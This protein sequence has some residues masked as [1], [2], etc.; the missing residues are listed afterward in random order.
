MN[1]VIFL[2]N[3]T[4]D[5]ELRHSQG[6]MGIY[7]NSLAVSRKF[8]KNGEKQEEVLFVDFT[9]FARTSE[10]CNQYLKKG[11]KILVEGRLNFEQWIGED[12]QKR[13]KHSVTV[14]SMQMLDSKPDIGYA[15]TRDATTQGQNYDGQGGY[16]APVQQTPAQVHG[17]DGQ[18][19]SNG[20]Q[21]KDLPQQR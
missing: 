12:G 8:T 15:P 5:G 17:F 14:E 2:G 1:K 20:Y 18:Q 9:A 11:S 21:Q 3:C 4:K 6:G 7:K 19:Q 13:S 16:H 10:I